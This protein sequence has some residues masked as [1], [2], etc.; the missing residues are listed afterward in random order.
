M[1]KI[2]HNVLFLMV[3]VDMNPDVMLLKST[4]NVH[5]SPPV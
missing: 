3:V 2:T 1:L 5:Q 4:S